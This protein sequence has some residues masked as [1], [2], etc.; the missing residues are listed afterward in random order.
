MLEWERLSPAPAR[1]LL[2]KPYERLVGRIE[3]RI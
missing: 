3:D 1:R 2:E